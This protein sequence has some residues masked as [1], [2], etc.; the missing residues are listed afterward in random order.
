MQTRLFKRSDFGALA[1]LI[2]DNART[3]DTCRNY[4][5]TSDLAWQMP[6][7][8]PKENIRLWFDDAAPVAYAW[9]QP[10]DNLICDIALEFSASSDLMKQMLAWAEQ[11]RR[12]FPDHFPFYLELQSMQEWR[13]A[14]LHL[15]T[16][17]RRTGQYLFIQTLESDHNL[18]SLLEEQGYQTT[19]HYEPV[20][21]RSLSNIPA[22]SGIC[23]FLSVTQPDYERRVQLH[24]D[25]WAPSSTFDL[26]RYQRIRDNPLFDGDLDIVAVMPDGNFASYTIAWKD[27]VSKI[28]SIEPFGTHPNYRGTSVSREVIYEAFR[29]LKARGMTTMRLG[30]AG[31]NHQAQRLYTSCGYVEVDR[32]RTYSKKLG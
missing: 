6:G 26:A 7:S 30:T 19:V 12:T 29:R 2:A 31:F 21:H 18:R 23:S 20:Y 16:P 10:P 25:A 22:P 27:D 4:L 14:M 5:M 28:G 15:N 3:R 24:R 13:E 11:R 8:A 17:H 1:N 32:R 9:F